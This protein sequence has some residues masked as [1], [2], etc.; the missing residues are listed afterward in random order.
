MDP[1]F[2]AQPPQSKE[3][4]DAA[5]GLQEIQIPERSRK[6]SELRLSLE[7]CP[8]RRLLQSS[9]RVLFAV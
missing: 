4:R 2:K 6:A 5:L 9:L 1:F 8:F 7:Y 3:A